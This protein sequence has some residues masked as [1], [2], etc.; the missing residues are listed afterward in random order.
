MPSY[1]GNPSPYRYEYAWHDYLDPASPAAGANLSVAVPGEWGLIVV[2]AIATLTTDGNAANRLLSLDYIGGRGATYVRNAAGK[3]E[4]AT[5]G[6]RTYVWSANRTVSESVANT[7]VFV[8]LLEW[9]LDPGMSVRF[10]I[11]NVQAGDQLSAVHLVVV[12]VPTGAGAQDDAA[13]GS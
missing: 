7:P 9:Q 2:A 8:P 5:N 12:K 11:D 4:T 13:G 10:T 6:G 1:A 3:V